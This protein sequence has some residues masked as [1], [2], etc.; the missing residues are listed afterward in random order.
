MDMHK[1]LNEI[2]KRIIDPKKGLSEEIFLFISKMTPLV[3]VDLLIKDKNKGTLL[4]WRD[5]IHGKGW[6]IPGG[7]LRFKEK[8]NDRLQKVAEEEIGT[9]I[10]FKNEPILIKEVINNHKIRGHFISFLFKCSLPRGFIINNKKLKKG[11]KGYLKWHD[12]CP[13]NLIKCHKMYKEY[14]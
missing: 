2:E 4:A 6:H 12:S 13:N 7:I 3:N 8:L 10:T 1:C 14:I 5:D 11:D 9:K